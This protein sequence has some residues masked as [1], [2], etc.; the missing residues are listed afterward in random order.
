[1]RVEPLEIDFAGDEEDDGAHRR[2]AGVPSRLALGGL[3]QSIEG[4]EE[5]IG[6]PSLRPC[7]PPS[8]W[9]QLWTGGHGYTT[10]GAWPRRHERACEPESPAGVRGT[11]K[12]GQCAWW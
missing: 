10:Y 8:S 9:V 12:P 2:K 7:G 6:L 3:E 1:M 11:A 5:P 4:F